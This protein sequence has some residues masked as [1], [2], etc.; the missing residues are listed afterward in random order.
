[1]ATRPDLDLGRL[2]RLDEMVTQAE[3]T[4]AG[5]DSASALVHAYMALRNEIL[6][7]FEGDARRE[8]CWMNDAT[9]SITGEKR[10]IAPVRR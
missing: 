7:L 5:R 1:M 4:K 10:A 6:S 3:Q 8:E 9:A 2:L